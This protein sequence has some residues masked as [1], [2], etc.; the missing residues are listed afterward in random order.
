MIVMK[1]LIWICRK[2]LPINYVFGNN[3]MHFFLTIKVYCLVYLLSKEA[4]ITVTNN[5]SSKHCCRST[6]KSSISVNI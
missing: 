1:V 6:N 3:A 5:S 2:L 4:I